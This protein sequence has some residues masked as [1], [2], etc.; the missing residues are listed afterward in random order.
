MRTYEQVGTSVLT[1]LT[2]ERLAEAE[3]LVD[4]VAELDREALGDAWEFG[5]DLTSHALSMLYNNIGMGYWKTGAAANTRGDGAASDRALRKAE[6][7]HEKALDMYDMSADDFMYLPAN[8]PINKN[9]ICTLRGLGVVKFGLGK[10]EE[11]RKYLL[12]MVRIPAEDEQAAFWQGEGSHLLRQL[13]RKPV[14]IAIQ[15]QSVRSDPV[16]PRILLV[17]GKLLEWGD[18]A[19]PIFKTYAASLE[20]TDLA[21]LVERGFRNAAGLEGHVLVLK[22]DDSGDLQRALRLVEIV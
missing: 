3:A 12:V 2:E 8:S 7:C 5:S 4:E 6:R 15:A 21:Q 13:D 22:T 9:T 10:E 11:S 17:K 14:Q 1:Y 20:D 18:Y 19:E 16:N